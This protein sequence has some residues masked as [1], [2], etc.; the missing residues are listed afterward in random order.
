MTWFL[1]HP[2]TQKK[3]KRLARGTN[4]PSISKQSLGDMEIPVPNIEKQ[5]L[6]IKISDLYKKELQMKDEIRELKNKLV[7]QKL[8]NAIKE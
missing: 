7:N 4:L 5:K 6:I 8:Y 2:N 1:N 3:F